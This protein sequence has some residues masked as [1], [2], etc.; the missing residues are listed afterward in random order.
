MAVTK[1]YLCSADHANAL[2]R[3]SGHTPCVT[4]KVLERAFELAQ[5]EIRRVDLLAEVRTFFQNQACHIPGGLDGLPSCWLRT[6]PELLWATRR[7]HWKKLPYM[8]DFTGLN[9]GV[10]CLSFAQEE[11]PTDNR[12]TFWD[13]L[14]I[15]LNQSLAPNRWQPLGRRMERDIWSRWPR[16]RRELF[17]LPAQ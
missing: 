8:I 16:L 6:L 15:H 11:A 3:A 2:M 17:Q 13:A 7:P 5:P 14:R 9:Q 4:L 10:L 12:L 1:A